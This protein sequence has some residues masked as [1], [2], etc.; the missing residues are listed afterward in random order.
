[1]A[2]SFFVLFLLDSLH[3]NHHQASQITAKTVFPIMIKPPF[4]LSLFLLIASTSLV[5]V[6]SFTPPVLVVVASRRRGSGSLV[7]G[8]TLSSNTDLLLLDD[9]HVLLNKA[10][11][12]AFGS[13]EVL[14]LD[15]PLFLNKLLELASD[16]SSGKRLGEDVCAL[17]D[18]MIVEVRLDSRRQ[19]RLFY[20]AAMIRLPSSSHT[21]MTLSFTFTRLWLS[22]ESRRHWPIPFGTSFDR[23]AGCLAGPP[24]VF[25]LQ[26]IYCFFI[27]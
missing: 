8:S 11:E 17:D 18:S 26:T 6:E 9:G 15:A 5:V 1:M 10:R 16:C 12:C 24:F 19:R 27:C 13:D 7:V 14:A 3:S 4:C 23:L 21:K 25:V 22:Y 2:H 20:L